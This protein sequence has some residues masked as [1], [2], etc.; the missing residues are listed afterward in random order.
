M[1]W[2]LNFSSPIV[3]V[4]LN[5]PLA[6]S[7]Y[8]SQCPWDVCVVKITNYKK[9]CYIKS[10]KEQG[11][12]IFNLWVFANHSAVHSWG[13]SRGRVL[14]CGCWRRSNT[15]AVFCLCCIHCFVQ[16]PC[17]LSVLY[18]L[19]NSNNPFSLSAFYSMLCSSSNR[20]RSLSVFYSML[21]SRSNRPRSLSVF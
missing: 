15:R 7:V 11:L 14:G 17:S 3:P 12:Q 20:P 1:C 4:S 18:S 5:R 6:V 19:L 9:I 16:V 13:V 10:Y 21:C 8:K 2:S